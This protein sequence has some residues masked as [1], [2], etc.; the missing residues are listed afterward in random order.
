M[1]MSGSNVLFKDQLYCFR[2]FSPSN[3]SFMET[4]DCYL[5]FVASPALEPYSCTIN[6]RLKSEHIC[7]WKI[8]LSSQNH[9]VFHP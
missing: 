7:E 3:A 9:S 2:V 5:S 6:E 8:L 1:D 4:G